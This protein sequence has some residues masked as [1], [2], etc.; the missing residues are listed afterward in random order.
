VDIPSQQLLAVPGSEVTVARAESIEELEK[1]IREAAEN[2]CHVAVQHSIE[3][4][5]VASL[6]LPQGS[7]VIVPNFLNKERKIE[8]SEAAAPSIRLT[9]MALVRD[10]VAEQLDNEAIRN[11]FLPVGADPDKSVL[12]GLFRNNDPREPRHYF[13]RSI[14]PLSS[15][16]QSF[17]YLPLS[18][19][20]EMGDFAV[21]KW[22]EESETS[23]TFED[24]FV[25]DATLKVRPQEARM[26]VRRL[27]VLY[28][29]TVFEKEIMDAFR[30][31]VAG[32]MAQGKLEAVDLTVEIF[33]LPLYVASRMFILITCCS[34][35]RRQ[36]DA[37]RALFPGLG[38]CLQ[39]QLLVD[40]TDIQG[41]GPGA[42]ERR[43]AF[44]LPSEEYG[45][46]FSLRD[47]GAFSEWLKR[48]VNAAAYDVNQNLQAHFRLLSDNSVY[49]NAVI[50]EP[51]ARASSGRSKRYIDSVPKFPLVNERRIPKLGAPDVSIPTARTQRA[52]PALAKS[53]EEP[54]LGLPGLEGI[55]TDKPGG[56]GYRTLREQYASY[57]GSYPDA[58]FKPSVIVR[59]QNSD[60][61]AKAVDYAKRNGKKVVVRSGGHHYCGFSSG[62]EKYVQVLMDDMQ[63]KQVDI[64]FETARDVRARGCSIVSPDGPGNDAKQWFVEVAARCHL[65]DVSAELLKCKLTIPHGECPLVGIGGHVQSG[66]YGHQMR[67]L[68]LCLDYVYSFDMVV[69]TKNDNSARLVTVYRPELQLNAEDAPRKDQELN[70]ELYKGVLGGSPGA[71]GVVTRIK[72]LT[73]HD[74]DPA[75]KE[76]HNLQGVYP[77]QGGDIHR[78]TTQVIRKMLNLVASK[79]LVEG[80]DVFIS[81]ISRKIAC[82]FEWGIVVPELAYTG[83]EFSEKVEDQMNEIKACCKANAIFFLKDIIPGQKLAARPPSGVAHNG[84]RTENNGVTAGG[85]EFDLAYKK[86]VNIMLDSDVLSG[87]RADDFADG[88][89]KL[90]AE[91]VLDSD[92]LLVVQMNLGGGKVLS[93]DV[94]RKTGIPYRNQSF[95]FVFDVFYMPAAESRAIDIQDRMQKLLNETGGFNRRLFWGSF[96]RERHE[97]DMSKRF[98]RDLY[99]GAEDDYRSVQ[100]I[101]DKVDPHGIFTTEFT[102]QNSKQNSWEWVW[103]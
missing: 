51:D 98:V 57:K 56:A 87:K 101:K 103:S 61:I 15:Y 47:F 20:T 71:F 46:T 84:V 11:S 54:T 75:V 83:G 7:V 24:K 30:R 58:S 35:S 26:E 10:L 5:D 76:S 80:L 31:N 18:P 102:V 36:D 90:V 25:L 69:L 88:F 91:V 41:M 64:S 82:K 67:G 99:F 63:D 73:V 32:A 1:L 50:F 97:T 52:A 34:T 44:N 39:A 13:Q 94:T 17:S 38:S 8:V 70:D 14:D 72:F 19:S 60:Q 9:R 4:R 2:E 40:P 89:G 28:E 93:N 42:P 74:N 65:R 49:A 59:P 16:V 66:G 48:A 37:I 43:K 53:A 85:R 55:K 12:S 100:A 22:D 33:N 77:Y 62:D 45:G 79:T 95:G 96:G 21:R 92:L 23:L 78:G 81:I 27:L 6:S 29:R 68:G 86:R 3:E